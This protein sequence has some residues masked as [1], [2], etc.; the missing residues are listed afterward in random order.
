MACV[1]DAK[2]A[3]RHGRRL[4]D[5]RDGTQTALLCRSVFGSIGKY[6]LLPH[7]IVMEGSVSGFQSALQVLLKARA[8]AGEDSWMRLFSPRIHLYSHPLRK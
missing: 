5:P 7:A 1:V 2:K 6:N 4:V 8:A 3:G